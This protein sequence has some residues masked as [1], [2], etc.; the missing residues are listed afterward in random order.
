[1]PSEGNDGDGGDEQNTRSSVF[2]RL[3]G[4]WSLGRSSERKWSV[5][6][7]R[8]VLERLAALGATG[9]TLP[10]LSR[11]AQAAT[12][13]P[14]S[15]VPYVA[16]YKVDDV[17]ALRRDQADADVEKETMVETVPRERWNRVKAA[18]R[19]S[20]GLTRALRNRLDVPFVSAGVT[21]DDAGRKE[22]LVTR[23]RPADVARADL[24]TD[25]GAVREALPDAVS[26][27]V[28]K[29][30]DATTLSNIPVRASE[31]SMRHHDYEGEYRP[32]PGGCKMQGGTGIGTFAQPVHNESQNRTEMLTAGHVV[33]DGNDVW[34]PQSNCGFFTCDDPIGSISTYEFL[35]NDTSFDVD[36][37]GDDDD[38]LLAS[39][40]AGTC[41]LNTGVSHTYRLA[42]TSAGD[43]WAD[44]IGIWTF[45]S[46]EMAEDDGASVNLQGYVSGLSFGDIM[47][48]DSANGWFVDTAD[49]QQGDS[50]GPFYHYDGNGEVISVGVVSAGVDTSGDGNFDDGTSGNAITKIF[51]RL[52]LR[53][54][55]GF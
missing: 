40:D 39:V 16:G 9:A 48:T 13:D 47:Y 36:G 33:D 21:T 18:H 14:G 52:D 43:Y 29:G 45:D 10:E 27:T 19:A 53:F 5:M 17:D 11:L 20:R 3:G 41:D 15:E 22:V 7:R 42:A 44:I 32:V 31:W 34:Q 28:G 1:M 2:G 24:P 25:F 46:I 55:A 4:R 35:H 37:D 26:A 6:G 12:D 30:R 51:D 49:S 38:V 23:R 54:H 8:G 50:G